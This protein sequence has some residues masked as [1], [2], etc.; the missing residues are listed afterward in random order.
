MLVYGEVSLS[1][2][3]SENTGDAAAWMLAACT[4]VQSTCK[5]GKPQEG[6]DPGVVH[7]QAKL[8]KHPHIKSLRLGQ[9]GATGLQ[10]A[11]T[12]PVGCLLIAAVLLRILWGPGRQKEKLAL[13]QRG[14]SL[15]RYWHVHV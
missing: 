8:W 9:D 7:V 10:S 13:E 2:W 1:E 11:A 3:I 5:L 12:L 4:S 14:D 6:I 15:V